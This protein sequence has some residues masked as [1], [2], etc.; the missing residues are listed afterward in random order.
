MA[1][2]KFICIIR[3][4]TEYVDNRCCQGETS[5][6]SRHEQGCKERS[7]RLGKTEYHGRA[8]HCRALVPGFN[9]KIAIA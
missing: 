5:V 7:S 4:K 1:H 6:F 3:M 8:R 9:P 2:R